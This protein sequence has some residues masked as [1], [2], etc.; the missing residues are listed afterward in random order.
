MPDTKSSFCMDCIADKFCQAQ[1]LKSASHYQGEI[2]RLFEELEKKFIKDNSHPENH[3]LSGNYEIS[4][5]EYRVLMS[6]FL[7]EVK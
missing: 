7:K 5:V 3:P 4:K 2:K 1:A 6:E